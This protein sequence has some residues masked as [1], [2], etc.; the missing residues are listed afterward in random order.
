MPKRAKTIPPSSEPPVQPGK[1]FSVEPVPLMSLLAIEPWSVDRPIPYAKNARVIPDSAVDLVAKSLQEFNW[2]QPIVV[3]E[4]GVVVVGHTRLKAAQ[5][6]GLKVV[7][8]H[9]MRGVP[10]DKIDAYRLMDN[11]SNQETMWDNDVLADELAGLKLTGYDLSNTGF[12]ESE[13][14]QHLE[15][16]GGDDVSAVVGTV[17]RGE[18]DRGH[19]EEPAQERGAIACPRCKKHFI[20]K[21]K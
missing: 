9:V 16:M 19:E 20:P 5:K 7:P 14:K 2:Q 13:L 3:D 1:Q 12:T 6:L 17:G 15:S 8:V 10:Q 4:A 18:D 11:R 21:G